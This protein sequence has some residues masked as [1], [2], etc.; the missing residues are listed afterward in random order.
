MGSIKL[1]ELVVDKDKKMFIIS[2][3]LR[4]TLSWHKFFLNRLSG[5]LKGLVYTVC[6]ALATLKTPKVY[7]QLPLPLN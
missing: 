2:C 4:E 1:V 5:C 7:H 3:K 6:I